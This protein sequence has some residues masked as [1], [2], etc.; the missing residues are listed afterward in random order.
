[1]V[2]LSPGD[3]PAPTLALAA[4]LAMIRAVEVAAPASG[5]ILKWPNDLLLG[6]RKLGGILLERSGERIVAGFGVNLLDA[7]EVPG[8]V[9]AALSEVAL[10]TPQAFAPL[11]AAAFA[12]ELDRWRSDP[13]GQRAL[14]L[15]S[16]HPI[17][18]ALTVQAE[19]G[20]P[21][22][23]SFAGLDLTGALQLRLADGQ[24]RVMHAADVEI[25]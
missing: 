20:E 16:A 21:V 9:T 11:L 13:A 19:P 18:T 4:G 12:R 6:R 10:V 23:G 24:V 1:M 17:G 22:E 3:P 15:E 5:L 8:R 25:V 2:L 14:W 7:P